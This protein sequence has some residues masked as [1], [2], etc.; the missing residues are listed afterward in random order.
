MPSA[1]TPLSTR[2]ASTSTLEPTVLPIT[3]SPTF[4]VGLWKCCTGFELHK[5]DGSY[6]FEHTL[7]PLLSRETEGQISVDGA[8]MTYVENSSDCTPDQIGKYKIN[9]KD[10]DTY[11]LTLIE[12]PCI[13][14]ATTGS[15]PLDGGTFYRLKPALP[16]GTYAKTLSAQDAEAVGS[17]L[18]P[19]A[20][21]WELQLHEGNKFELRHNGQL[22]DSDSYF[23][24]DKQFVR[25]APKLCAG[26]GEAIGTFKAQFEGNTASFFKQKADCERLVFVLRTNA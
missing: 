3:P 11:R 22:V 15:A 6:R 23:D 16:F 19:L 7:I 20:G 14:R 12:D 26:H 21:N 4:F 9:I 10:A 2:A 24:A 1:A 5:A 8:V 25:N 17:S 18:V 13:W